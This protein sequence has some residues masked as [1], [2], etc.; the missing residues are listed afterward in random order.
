MATQNKGYETGAAVAWRDGTALYGGKQSKTNCGGKQ[1][2][3]IIT[4]GQ[5]DAFYPVRAARF[6]E[7]VRML[8]EKAREYVH[9]GSEAKLISLS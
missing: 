3:L 6:F 5:A 7:I 2:H 1:I 8:V 4:T 9:Q